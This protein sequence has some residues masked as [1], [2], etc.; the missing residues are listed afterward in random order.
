MKVNAVKLL[1][2]FDIGLGVG[3]KQ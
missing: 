2:A 1:E 3:S